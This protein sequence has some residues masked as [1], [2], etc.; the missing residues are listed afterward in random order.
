MKVKMI[1]HY[2]DR[3]VT[4]FPDQEADVSAALGAWLIEHRKAQA[5]IDARHLNVE[6]QFE[7]AEEPPHYGGQKEPELRHDDKKSTRLKGRKGQEA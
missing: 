7:Q 6:P 4:L 5:V 1:E 3:D 2:Q